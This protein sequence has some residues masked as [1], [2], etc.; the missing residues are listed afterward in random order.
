M[1][2]GEMF[3]KLENGSAMTLP[4]WDKKGQYIYL[5]GSKIPGVR[6]SI[7]MNTQVGRQV[8]WIPY[9]EDLLSKEWFE[10]EGMKVG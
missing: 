6:P 3:T 7:M 4:K 10:K 5:T 1:T 2:V 9:Q 8:L